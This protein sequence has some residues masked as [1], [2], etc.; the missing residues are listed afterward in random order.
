MLLV[1][2]NIIKTLP[3]VR[4]EL[5]NKE[6]SFLVLTNSL[7]GILNIFKNHF[8]YKFEILTCISAIDYPDKL[9]RFEIVYELLSL[10]FNARLKIKILVNE[11]I[12]IKSIEKIFL[13]AT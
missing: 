10:K 4:L 3:I 9:Y 6:S 7:Y 11:L 8:K 5:Y 2:E 13:G 12:P 1:P